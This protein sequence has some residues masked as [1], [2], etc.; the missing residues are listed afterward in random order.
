L[1]Q[2]VSIVGKLSP[3]PR[4]FRGPTMHLRADQDR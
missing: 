2:S 1:P 4:V 3:E